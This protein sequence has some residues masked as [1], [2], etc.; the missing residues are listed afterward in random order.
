MSTIP[1][2]DLSN[3]YPS[4]ESKEFEAAVAKVK[5]QIDDLEKLFAEKI[6]KMDAKTPVKTLAPVVVQRF[7]RTCWDGT[8]LHQI[9]CRH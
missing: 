5:S 3:V 4:L 1:H 8:R 6:S 7:V 2:W 9:L